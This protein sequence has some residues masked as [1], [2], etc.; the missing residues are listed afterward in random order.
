MIYYTEEVHEI[1]SESSMKNSVRF[2]ILYS[3][4]LW[5]HVRVTLIFW[6]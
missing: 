6:K 3:V 5:V 4:R 2:L 1:E